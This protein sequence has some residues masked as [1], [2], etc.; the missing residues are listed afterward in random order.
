MDYYLTEHARAALERRKISLQW[1][2]Q[3]LAAPE[4]TEQDQMGESL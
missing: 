1:M 3:V 4:W 2:E